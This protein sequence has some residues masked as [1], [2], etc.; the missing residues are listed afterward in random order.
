MPGPGLML[1]QVW[2]RPV[3]DP[4][5]WVYR[6]D[7]REP[8]FV[9]RDAIVNGANYAYLI[10]SHDFHLNYSDSAQFFVSA[11]PAA[12]L[13]PRQIGIRPT[14]AYWGGGGEQI[15]MQSGNLNYTLPV[16]Q[17]KARGGLTASFGLNYNSQ[18][19]RKDLANNA[20]WYY[21]RDNGY[22]H[23]WR[24]LTGSILAVHKAFFEM[25]FFVYTDSTG[26]NTGWM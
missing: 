22:G 12:A 24:L 13:D 11:P 1:Y 4:N 16:V 6:G 25:A 17:A 15:D 14:G 26:P 21:G 20:T 23:G 19:W 9:D 3:S 2:R 18:I 10:K 7:T 8:A 5:G